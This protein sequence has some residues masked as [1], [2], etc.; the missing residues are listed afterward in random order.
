MAAER[1]AP[2]SRAD[3]ARLTKQRIVDTALALFSSQGYDATS[4]QDIAD[5]LGLTK[6]AV[7]Y[8]FRSKAEILAAV[9]EPTME[10]ITLI[11]EAAARLRTRRARIDALVE[12]FVDVM[13]DQRATMNVLNNDPVMHSQVKKDATDI[14]ALQNR[15]I[16]M[17]YGD[18][19]TVDQ[20]L[21]IFAVAGIVDAAAFMTDV[22]N[23][24][25]RPVIVRAIRRLIP[26][27]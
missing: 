22:S 26:D 19:P 5:A 2:A 12:G 24:D 1:V 20:R 8:H 6:A 27:R 23:A 25:I 11:V 16:E 21:A 10:A 9:A 14:A 7:Y 13:L 3:K 17:I 18:H 15:V 4:L